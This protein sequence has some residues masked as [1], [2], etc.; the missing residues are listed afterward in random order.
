[1]QEIRIKLNE[2]CARKL[3]CCVEP[4]FE[5][6]RAI[7]NKIVTLN[8]GPFTGKVMKHVSKQG[9]VYVRVTTE[10]HDESLKCW[11]GRDLQSDEEA[12]NPSAG[13]VMMMKV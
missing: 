5:F 3:R 11:Y 12:D 7:G 9:R 8:C 6:V 4:N 1:M 2:I 13:T 10:V